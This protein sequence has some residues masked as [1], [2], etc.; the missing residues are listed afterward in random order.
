MNV[1]KNGPIVSAVIVAIGA[2]L[3]AA[4]AWPFTHLAAIYHPGQYTT[5]E[6]VFDWITCSAGAVVGGIFFS[7]AGKR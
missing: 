6:A 1:Q 4:V 2:L 3:G 5:G 7:W